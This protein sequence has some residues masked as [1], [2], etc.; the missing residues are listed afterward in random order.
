MIQ[1]VG[2]FPHRTI[3]GTSRRCR[4]SLG[5]DRA[6]IRERVRELVDLVGLD[7]GCS[8]DIHRS[9]RGQQQASVSPGPW[10]PILRSC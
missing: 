10:P 9:S 4:S 5:W 3:E 1:Q 7:P 2:L 6:R 8:G